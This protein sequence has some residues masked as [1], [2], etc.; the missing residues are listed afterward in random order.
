M[1]RQKRSFGSQKIT[2]GAAIA[3]LYVILTYLCS[4]FGLSSGVIQL[5]IS[6]A[7]CVLPAFFPEAIPG[8][9]VGCMISN[10]ISL[11]APWDV[12][13]GSIAT[14]IGAIGAYL[15]RK[16][17][18]KLGFLITLPNI[19]SNTV[20]IP[21]IL[22]YVYAVEDGLPFL[23]LTVGIG[24]IVSCGVLGTVL[25]YAVRKKLDRS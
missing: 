20:I 1:N 23:A 12:V 24:E 21:L 6:E 10:L 16:V 5:R 3:A 2:R 4:L 7:L 18:H 22:T 25:Y 14:L 17:P 9:F 13:F 8:L 15:L 19:V 11:C